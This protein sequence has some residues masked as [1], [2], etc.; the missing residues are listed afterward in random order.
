MKRS[1]D[2]ASGGAFDCLLASLGPVGTAVAHDHA[3]EVILWGMILNAD[4]ISA[5]A[6]EG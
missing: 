5:V 2:Y 3:A 4:V 6:A 1:E